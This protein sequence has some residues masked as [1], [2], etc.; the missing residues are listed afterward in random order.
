MPLERRV[1][2]R[3]VRAEAASQA[4]APFAHQ[5][6]VVP[7]EYRPGKWRQQVHPSGL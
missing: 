2:Q 3:E 1:R 5:L 6:V 7:A 4:L